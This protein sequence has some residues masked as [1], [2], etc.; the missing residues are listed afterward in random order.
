MNPERH[1]KADKVFKIF[2]SAVELEG[3][4]RRA[5]LDQA[6]A[7]DPELRKE[8]E[9]LLGYDDRAKSFIESPAFEESPELI[10]DN[11]VNTLMMGSVGPFKLLSR[12]GAG[13][14]GEVYLAE[15]SR[16]GRKVALKILP[17]YFSRDQD[18]VGRFKREAKAASALNHP[19]VATIY[20]IGEAE[21]ISYIAMEYVE[22]ET[23]D[24]KISGQPLNP[25]EIVEIAS[26]VADALDEAHSKGITHRDIKS[27]NIMLTARMQ[28]KV[29]DF[30]LAKV[31]TAPLE[32][33][34]SEMATESQTAPGI[35]M[36]TVQ[37]M[38]PEQALGKN[39]DHRT[40]I[41]SCGVV[42]YEMATGRL[43]FRA[44]TATETIERIIHAQPEA[45]ARF[46]YDVSAELERIIR[47]CL[48]KDKDRRYQTAKELRVDLRN[49]KRDSDSA[50]PNDITIT[51]QHSY[52]W[53][54]TS[55]VAAILFVAIAG[56]FL[57]LRDNRG[58][59]K[60]TGAQVRSIAVLPFKP[61]LAET[62]DQA[63]EMGMADTLIAR[64]SNIS[65][66]NVRPISA[67]RK[68]ADIE[69]DALAAGREQK[70]DA[71]LDGQIQKSGDS[72][73]VTVR[74]SRVEDG[75]Q[76]WSSQ[77]D[78]RMT[79]IFQVQ[80]S[81]SERVAGALALRMTAPEQERLKKRDTENTDAYE[82][83]LKGRYHLN[84]L[85][86]DGFLKG[87]EYFRQAI[88]KDPNFALAHV[89]VADSY[90]NLAGFNVRPP[91]E[92]LPKA[93][94]AALMALKLD[95]TLAQGHTALASAS[96]ASWDWS[97]AERE[98]KRAIELNPS[99]DA[100]Y[101]YG[102]YLAFIG[103]SEEALVEMRRARELDPVS[104]VKITGVVQILIL[105]R[106]Y[107]ESIEE[108][109]RAIE[110]D[111]NLG[112]AHW[113]LGLAYMYKGTYEPAVHSF[114]KAIPL[115]GESPDELASLAHAYALSG[116]RTEAR[117]ILDKLKQR[118]EHT[119]ISPATIADLYGV[120][121]DKDQAFALLEKAYDQRDTFLVVLKA[122]PYFDPLRSDPRFTDLLRRVGFP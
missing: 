83:Y 1:E 16:L 76:I 118:A 108:C 97:D 28:A 22:G 102:Y 66:I 33:L 101:G 4:S 17:E 117:K 44:A 26:H 53:R 109:R 80:D 49:L 69:Q 92:V 103:K 85:T 63:L 71:V 12:L 42:M 46:S 40:D 96:M 20:E 38:S 23:L 30:G 68:Y 77:F 31:S 65:E 9:A 48:E 113:L 100:H 75:G 61:L 58:V 73:R 52:T 111:P 81:I 91:M 79:N 86:D 55:I 37:Y 2:Q 57:L 116:K 11:G 99:S 47:K 84:R 25:I 74:L 62:R 15:D 115:S 19:N 5:H 41:F 114:Q 27:A 34:N 10:A 32:C 82:L 6:C 7:G 89:G 104:L 8:V 39:V 122:D 14:M 36:G 43:P 24:S 119:Y 29:L 21:G 50:A 98:F 59:G 51:R 78:E 110:M 105:A 13:G 54:Q 121:G 64:L 107:D 90:N 18:R 72:I 93:K 3:D 45:I 88:E 35:V 94:S 120:L 106:R 60:K 112:Y 70:V 87:L 95:D 67:V 56:V